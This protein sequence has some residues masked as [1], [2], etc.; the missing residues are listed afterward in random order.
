MTSAGYGDQRDRQDDDAPTFS[1]AERA[2]NMAEALRAYYGKLPMPLKRRKNQPPLSLRT[3]RCRTIVDVGA[4]FLVG[5]EPSFMVESDGGNGAQE[6]LDACWEANR[7]AGLLNEAATNGGIFGDAYLKVI[8]DGVT[9]KGQSYPRIVVLDPQQVSIET[10]PDDCKLVLAYNIVWQGVDADGKAVERRQRIERTDLPEKGDGNPSTPA[11]GADEQWLIR[12]QIRDGAGKQGK[13]EYKDVDAP[14]AWEYPWCPIHHAPNL[15]QPNYIY[16]AAD[17]TPDI[18]ELQKALN[19]AL[20]NRN[21]ILYHHAHPKTWGKGFMASQLDTS[22]DGV[23]IIQSE[24]GSLQNLEMQTDL[25]GLANHIDDL[26]SDMD[27]L[28]SVP[29]VATG[30]LKDLGKGPVPGITVRMMFQPLVTK[31]QKKQFTYGAMLES[32]CAHLLEMMG[33]GPGACVDVVWQDMLPQS[34]AEWAQYA[35]VLQQMGVSKQTLISEAGYDWDAE[36]ER[37]A[38]ESAG[39][40]TGWL[41]GQGMPP[42]MPPG[43]D[44]SMTGQQS[45]P[46]SQNLPLN[47]PPRRKASAAAEGE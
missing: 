14:I 10:D 31:T 2:R 27:E 44:P 13:A 24:G 45:G 19:F 17:I 43:M 29:G 23:F 11:I 35:P 38:E 28:S 32:L 5:K 30:R 4:A 36:R 8:P 1:E 25:A 22:V 33:Q 18:V 15:E 37:T 20:S 46:P 6:A 34:M 9:H 3:N 42:A 7:L 41:R 26:R 12:N 21:S 16:G 39:Q 40:M 47:Y